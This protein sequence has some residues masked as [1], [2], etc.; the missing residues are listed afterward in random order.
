MSESDGG[1]SEA[2]SNGGYGWG[3]KYLHR[4]TMDMVRQWQSASE[5]VA[6]PCEATENK[7]ESGYKKDT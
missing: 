5:G 1:I 7:H 2:V 6:V 3:M 4:E